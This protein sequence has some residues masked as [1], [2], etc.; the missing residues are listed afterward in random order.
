MKLSEYKKVMKTNSNL[1][2]I[3]KYNT[4]IPTYKE[5]ILTTP[6]YTVYIEKIHDQNLIAIVV[7]NSIESGYPI[8]PS[9]DGTV[10]V[11]EL[12][13]KVPNDIV[14]KFIKKADKAFNN[15]N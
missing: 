4:W 10:T 7:K 11:E 14:N 15:L 9:F 12:H 2:V 3:E 13:V 5:Q 8:F 6:E 1:G